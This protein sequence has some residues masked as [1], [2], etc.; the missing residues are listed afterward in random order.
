MKKGLITGGTGYI[1][2]RLSNYLIS[3]GFEVIIGTSKKLIHLPAQLSN[4]K[5]HYIDLASKDSL[6][7]ACEGVDIII[8]LASLNA[9][10]SF[11]YPKLAYKVNTLGTE[12]LINASIEK[13]VKYF[14]YFSTAH[15]YGESFTGLINETSSTNSIHPYA[16]SHEAAERILLKNILDGGINGT[17][18][19]LS[20]V[21]GAP[22]FKEA[23]CWMLFINDICKQAII[24]KEIIINSNAAIERDFI[25]MTDVC[26]IVRYFSNEMPDNDYPLYNV[27]SGK[28]QKLFD[29]A[30]IVV[31]RCEALFG[32]SPKLIYS[33]NQ[34]A[35]TLQYQISKI[36]NEMDFN[37]CVDISSDIDEVLSFCYSNFC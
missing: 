34:S 24:N 6:L 32:F 29:V 22:L 37:P 4:Y 19:R 11:E 27:G 35:H 30:N 8:H 1:G 13:K 15:V 10:E 18:F 17:I 28:S 2:G 14:L 7:V 20:N 9:K 25:S 5:S 23:N 33:K 3:N 16:A 36:S 21:I 31:K 26:R 12:N